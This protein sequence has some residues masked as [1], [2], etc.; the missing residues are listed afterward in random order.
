MWRQ[1]GGGFT[2]VEL[3]VVVVV[4]A[5]LSGAVAPSLVRA[6]RRAGART[7]AVQSFDLLNFAY[8]AAVMRR[9]PV[10][11]GFDAGRNA[12]WASVEAASLPWLSEGQDASATTTLVSVALPERVE[13]TFYRGDVTLPGPGPAGEV[14][15]IRF[16]PDGTA[17]DFVVEL[18]DPGGRVYVIEVSAATGQVRL[19]RE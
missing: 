16:E 4:M 3:M 14:D 10:T 9:Q 13:M 15:A 17:E 5:V 11:V 1:A 6:A 8:A 7:A 2:L 12:C 19:G 18:A